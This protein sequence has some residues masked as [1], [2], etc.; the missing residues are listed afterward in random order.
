MSPYTF[1]DVECPVE[2]PVR[3][4]QVNISLNLPGG[5]PALS[6]A[7][8]CLITSAPGATTT[9]TTATTTS[10]VTKTTTVTRTVSAGS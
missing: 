1:Y 9:T 10:Q 5:T 8:S 4:R 6:S 7:C 2:L 3:K